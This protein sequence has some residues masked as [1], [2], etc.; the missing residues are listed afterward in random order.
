MNHWAALVIPITALLIPMV[1][2][3]VVLVVKFERHKRAMEHAE[4]M[5]ALELGRT[6][7]QDEPWLS[8]A[9]LSALIGVVV[10]ISVFGIAWEACESIGYREEI[11]L[12]A[13]LV[14]VSGVICGTILA[15][16]GFELRA[17]AESSPSTAHSLAKS[18]FDA[19]A[20]DVSGARG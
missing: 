19:D 15:L 13:G 11:F 16:K 18:H 3:P 2:V 7:P 1:I 9:K 10:P 8:P 17:R 12:F 5:R 6:L 20:Y 14:G 4:R